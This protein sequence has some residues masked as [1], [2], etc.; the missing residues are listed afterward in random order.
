MSGPQ[1]I[2]EGV[3]RLGQVIKER[4]TIQK[5]SRVRRVAGLRALV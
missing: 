1:A 5:K 4:M 3:K 2:E